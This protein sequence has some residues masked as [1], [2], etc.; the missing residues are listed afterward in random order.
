VLEFHAAH[1]RNRFAAALQALERLRDGDVRATAVDF[2]V[3]RPS[4]A[5]AYLVS[6]RPLL[7]NGRA[8]ATEK[9]VAIAFIRDPLDRNVAAA[10][11][12]RDVF[13][14]TPSEADLAQALQSGIALGDYARARALSLNTVYTHLRRIRE[15]TGCHR[16]PELI[17]KLNDLQ[18]PLRVG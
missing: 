5:P 4:G 14:L 3:S 10:A 7:D 17:R 12:M 6:V 16:I 13:G 9:A 1:A 11:I 2:P 8:C 15:K 18:V